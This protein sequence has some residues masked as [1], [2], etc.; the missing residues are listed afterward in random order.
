MTATTDTKLRWTGADLE[1]FPE[2]DK[3]YEIIDGDLYVTHAPHWK[4]QD[5]INNLGTY[6]TLWSK[7]HQQGKVLQ[8]PGLIFANDDNVIPDLIWISRAKLA[9]SVDESGHFIT[10]PELIV[11]V[12]S[13]TAK[14]I[15]RDRQ[16]KLKL[17]SRVGVKEYWI[18]DWQEQM[19]EIYRRQEAFLQLA[20]TLFVED[21]LTSP[22]FPEFSLKVAEIFQ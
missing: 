9:T 19:V 21:E 8:T 3:R 20:Y 13:Q 7:K 10:A 4:H 22:I 15:A 11:E 14:D 2:N 16:V 12:L 6:L 5:A 18:V 17:Y 1:L